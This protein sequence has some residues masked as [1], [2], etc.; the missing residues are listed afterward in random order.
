MESIPLTVALGIFQVLGLPGLIFVIWHFDNKRLEKRAEMERELRT[1][2]IAER[3]KAIEKILNAYR[4][5]VREISQYYKDN[6]HLVKNWER[7]SGDMV[8]TIRLNTAAWQALTSSLQNKIP[9]YQLIA[10]G[11]KE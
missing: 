1:K 9:C 3:E 6:V 10:H 8:D 4:D 2:E 7:F 11:V 5:D